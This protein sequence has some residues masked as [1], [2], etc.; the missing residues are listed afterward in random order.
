MAR[1]PLTA[2]ALWSQVAP[3]QPLPEPP[4]GVKVHLSACDGLFTSPPRPP[5][6]DLPLIRRLEG[7]PQ[8]YTTAQ[9][10]RIDLAT[11]RHHCTTE[12]LLYLANATAAEAALLPDRLVLRTTPTDRNELIRLLGPEALVDG[13]LVL[14]AR[15]KIHNFESQKISALKLLPDVSLVKREINAGG[16]QGEV[17]LA[18][19]PE[20]GNWVLLH[21]NLRYVCKETG[22][23]QSERGG[24]HQQRRA[25]PDVGLLR[26]IRRHRAHAGAGDVQGVGSRA[27]DLARGRLVAGRRRPA[28]PRL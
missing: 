28:R 12:P 9:G 17:G 25:H 5:A 26:C 27:A 8:F 13:R 7:L 3:G 22:G 18:A 14:E 21:K 24:R 4:G 2:E 23:L 16:I 20:D 19:E 11:L 15:W 10:D 6:D 1:Q